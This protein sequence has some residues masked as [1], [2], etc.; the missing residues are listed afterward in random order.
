MNK[1]VNFKKKVLAYLVIIMFMVVP[2][3]NYSQVNLGWSKSSYRIHNGPFG[4]ESSIKIKNKGSSFNFKYDGELVVS[5]DDKEVTSIADGG[6]LEIE[7]SSF[8]NKRRVL[9]EADREGNL[10]RKYFMGTRG[11]K[12]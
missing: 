4:G 9:I 6:F 10:T 1:I 12:L 5:D 2:N 8:G 3:K 11:E 7:K